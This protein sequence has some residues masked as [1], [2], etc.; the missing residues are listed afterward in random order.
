MVGMNKT[1]R[2]NSTSL[3][4]ASAIAIAFLLGSAFSRMFPCGANP[5]TNDFLFGAGSTVA[6]A[7]PAAVT[8]TVTAAAADKQQH[9]TTAVDITNVQEAVTVC[10]PIT[11]VQKS[12]LQKEIRDYEK[13]KRFTDKVNEVKG[14]Q[15]VGPIHLAIEKFLKENVLQ[16]DWSVLELGCAAGMMLK[17]VQQAYQGGIGAH[18][19]LVGV[20]LV[21]GWVKFAQ[22]YHNDIKVFE[23]DITEFTLPEPY[24]AKTFDFVMLNDVAEHI[25]K[26]RYGC[27]FQNLNSL[28]HEGSIVYM[29]TPTPQAQLKDTDQ[30]VE[31][32]LP[33]HYLVMGMAL[34]GFELVTF[35]HDLDTFCKEKVSDRESIPL[36][37]NKAKCIYNEWPKYYHAVFRKSP[38]NVL[39]LT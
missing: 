29:H 13:S 20:E 23:G 7:N 27:F 32:V 38:K 17:L 19:E 1:E 24:A 31:N 25:Q 39:Q 2:G 6:L 9:S 4:K 33:H 35:E 37:I 14:T 30:Y 21:T 10:I 18:K 8:T 26:E 3:V 12:A 34:A 15:K 22:S 36:G 5:A 28:T 11:S 16:P